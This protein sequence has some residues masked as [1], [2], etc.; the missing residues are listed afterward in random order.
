VVGAPTTVRADQPL[1]CWRSIVI[2][3]PGGFTPVRIRQHLPDA[4]AGA[5]T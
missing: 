2:G 5:R 1:P 4:I 3:V